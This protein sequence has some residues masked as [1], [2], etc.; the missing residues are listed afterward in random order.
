MF[1]TVQPKS[2][3]HHPFM[4]DDM[5]I[6][7]SE[8]AYEP[9]QLRKNDGVIFAK[10]AKALEDQLTETG[11]GF[12]PEI[13][14][15]P[16]ERV[17]TAIPYLFHMELM[18]EKKQKGGIRFFKVSKTGETWLSLSPK[19]KLKFLIDHMIAEKENYDE[20]GYERGISLLPNAYD[21]IYGFPDL[22]SEVIDIFRTIPSHA[23]IKVMDFFNHFATEN[24]PISEHMNQSKFSWD[25]F[26]PDDAVEIWIE[27]LDLFYSN[28]LI[29]FGGV[30]LGMI[31]K[32][33]TAI[34]LSEIGRYILGLSTDFEFQETEANAIIIQPNFE[35]FFP[36]P[37]PQAEIQLSKFAERKGKHVGILF[38][39]TAS[40]I[41]Q[42][43]FSGLTYETIITTLTK[44]SKKTVP[45]NVLLD[46]K[47]RLGQIRYID[48]KNALVIECPDM[49]A[50]AKVYKIGGKKIKALSD[51]VLIHSDPTQ[52]S[53][54]IRKLREQGIF[55][56]NKKQ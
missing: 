4:L 26:R 31:N 32:N 13:Q 22:R 36:E 43:A 12:L 45:D 17:S 40:S 48:I 52:R 3:F 24:N 1:Q 50:A 14:I 7:L 27:V 53:V 25:Y 56:N 51:T 23:Y 41:K 49:D 55:V 37:S 28:R 15:E 2:E 46:I 16:A 9:F 5:T 35:I 54:I 29:P 30:H 8:C 6:I 19:K 20:W 42:A 44:L 39:I 33:E 18:D 21:Y 11:H 38:E 47:E 34:R 10:T